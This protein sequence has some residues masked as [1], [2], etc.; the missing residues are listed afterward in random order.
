VI[1]KTLRKIKIM[2]RSTDLLMFRFSFQRVI[3]E[4][5]KNEQRIK[6]Q[7]ML[8]LRIQKRTLDA[9]QKVIK[10]FLVETFESEFYYNL[11]FMRCRYNYCVQ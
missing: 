6:K 7:H 2:Q 1:D 9:L 8:N 11:N 5:M 4:I 10:S 3:K